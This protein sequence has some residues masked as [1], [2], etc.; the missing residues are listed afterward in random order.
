ME[1]AFCKIWTLHNLWLNYLVKEKNQ[2]SE[3]YIKQD[4]K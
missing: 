1:T 4:G 2:M 3:M